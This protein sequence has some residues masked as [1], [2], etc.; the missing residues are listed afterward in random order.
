M[1]LHLKQSRHVCRQTE[2]SI[3]T[4][5][6]KYFSGLSFNLGSLPKTQNVEISKMFLAVFVGISKMFGTKEID[7]SHPPLPSLTAS[8]ISPSFLFSVIIGNHKV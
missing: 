3:K 1:G 7:D 6:Y 5:I 2:K 4:F 8:I